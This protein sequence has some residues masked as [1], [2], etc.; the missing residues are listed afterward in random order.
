MALTIKGTPQKVK[1]VAASL[2]GVSKGSAA[3]GAIKAAKDMEEAERK[4]RGGA[5][6]SKSR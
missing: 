2:H 6:G 4:K 5:H 3:Q 1:E